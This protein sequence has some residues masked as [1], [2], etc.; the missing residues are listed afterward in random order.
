MKKI[1]SVL[2][3]ILLLS[4]NLFIAKA[5]SNVNQLNNTKMNDQYVG[6]WY[7]SLDS[8][9]KVDIKVPKDV[10]NKFEY[11]IKA[12][13]NREGL[14]GNLWSEIPEG[15]KL[16]SVNLVGDILFVDLNSQFLTGITSNHNM[17]FII[18]SLKNTIFQFDNINSFRI[19]IDGKEV[20]YINDYQMSVFN[21]NAANINVI[22]SGNNIT[23]YGS[24]DPRPNPII[25]LDA[26]HGGSAS[27]AVS[28]DGTL[29]KDINLAIT[30][31]VRDLLTN[32]GATVIMSRTTD[33]YK[34]M[35]DRVSE[36]NNS[37]ANFIVTIHSNSSANTS[38]RGTQS[39]YPVYHDVY[40]SSE[41]AS[42]I[43][44]RLITIFPQFNPITTH[45]GIGLLTSTNKPAVLVEMGFMS[46]SYDLQILK[47]RQDDIAL[48]IYVGIRNYWWGY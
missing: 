28:S 5:S 30:L 24:G 35:D 34:S 43:H 1:V 14:N 15:S 41:V 38:P 21:R 7:Q 31:K 6:V 37:N 45:D 17:S 39:F 46:N 18:N 48:Q 10:D 12:L 4:S 29:E 20:G 16:N 44:N 13:L 27:G 33:V 40:V 3:A 2:I 23:P 19:T 32:A 9:V 25:Y 36:A 47:T 11:A 8:Q 22:P 42:K 26:G